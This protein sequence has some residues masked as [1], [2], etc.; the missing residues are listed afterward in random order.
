MQ[1][2]S[3]GII[4]FFIALLVT[5]S[6]GALLSLVLCLAVLYAVLGMPYR[7]RG[8]KILG[9]IALLTGIFLFIDLY[10]AQSGHS[11]VA[12]I[13]FIDFNSFS[14][15]DRKSLWFSTW[16]M[17]RDYFWM[18]PG[19]G[20]FHFYYMSYRLP[21]DYSDGYFAHMDP[22]QF[23]AEM[24]VMAPVLFYVVLIAILLRT[25]RAV[26]AVP[27]EN[28]LRMRIMAPFLA[29][30]AVVGHAHVT[31]HMYILPIQFPLAVLL[32]YWYV[33]TEKALGD[34]RISFAIT[35][36]A[37]RKMA[38]ICF[39][40]LAL[41]PVQWS[42]RTAVSLTYIHKVQTDIKAGNLDMARDRMAVVSAISPASYYHRGQYEARWR[43]AKMARDK[44]IMSDDE[45]RKL[46]E[47]ALAHVNEAVELNP[48]Y[49]GVRDD[50]A[51]LYYYAHGDVIPNGYDLA[52]EEL[53]Q[54]MIDNPM[55]LSSRVGLANF[56]KKKGELKKALATLEGGLIWPRVKG[57]SEID[58]LVSIGRLRLR[59][60]DRKGHDQMI[61]EAALRARRYG[62][63]KSKK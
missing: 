8:L 40:L 42:V 24:G 15:V 47:E 34:K 63:M 9:S 43:V 6:R 5:Q 12:D 19:L 55:F 36:S 38:L 61:M 31:F 25:I 13:A 53:E 60:G 45:Y 49:V 1:N 14:V 35:N 20:T 57:Q 30:L 22:L 23:W 50:R 3:V 2:K 18:G 48:G 29:L 46:Y 39:A 16:D 52:I 17:I 33:M 27:K 54:V 44:E 56:Y 11:S 51:R 7:E 28:V 10:M 58:Y 32:A 41:Y 37:Y 4:L 62:L 21:I 26:R 59:L